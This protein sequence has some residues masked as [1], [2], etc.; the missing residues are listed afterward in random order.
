MISSWDEKNRSKF[1]F[2]IDGIV[3]KIDSIVG[4]TNKTKKPNCTRPATH[5]LSLFC[6]TSLFSSGEVTHLLPPLEPSNGT[7]R[8]T[9]GTKVDPGLQVCSKT[10]SF[11]AQASC[12]SGAFKGIRVGKNGA[13]LCF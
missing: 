5:H 7:W 6:L 1:D 3:A 13:P 8:I 9:E 4:L 2:I 12:T 11:P 10:E